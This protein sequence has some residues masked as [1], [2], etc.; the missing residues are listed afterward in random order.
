M[1][2]HEI[3]YFS[4]TVAAHDLKAGRCNEQNDL[5]N[6]YE[7]QRLRSF[8]DLGQR[9]LG[10]NI[11]FSKTVELFETKDFGR[12]EMKIYTNWLGHMTKM[13]ATP[14]Y[15]KNLSKNFLSRT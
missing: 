1:G 12:T 14:I 15:G 5:M 7:D 4:K 6:L 3:I 10:F 11:F 13:A 9:S 2:K 8:F